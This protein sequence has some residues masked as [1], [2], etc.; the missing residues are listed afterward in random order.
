MAATTLG[1]TPCGSVT[2]EVE[3]AYRC[4]WQPLTATLVMASAFA[5]Y[6]HYAYGMV[7]PEPSEVDVTC[8][9]GSTSCTAEGCVGAY[10]WVPTT[11]RKKAIPFETMSDAE[12]VADLLR[13]AFT[14]W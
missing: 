1:I 14:I 10:V 13:Q 2:F 11:V 9:H 12:T 4:E 5:G 7:D 3:G 8:T 6:R